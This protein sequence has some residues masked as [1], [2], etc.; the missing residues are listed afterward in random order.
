MSR[1]EGRVALVA[2]GARGIGERVAQ[3]FVRD[4]GRVII[5]DVNAE[6][7]QALAASLGEAAVWFP[8]NVGDPQSCADFVDKGISE[9]GRVDCLVNSA[10]RIR[11]GALMDLSLDDWNET[12]RIGLTGTF[13]ATQ[14]FGRALAGRPGS[15]VNISSIGGRFPYSGSGAYTSVKGAIIR[16]TEQ[17]ALEWASLGIR[18]NAVAPAH[19]E[20]P[21]LAYLQDPEVRRTRSEV[22]PLGRVG[23][24]DD[25]SNAILWLLS[26]EAS[27]VTATT[28]DIDGGLG[29]S[30]MNHLAGRK[31]D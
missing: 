12:L 30:I 25:I 16:L 7:G 14:A 6:L 11:S 1:F 22:T 24:P 17:F 9:F 19:V 4:G 21:L 13:L 20:T 29:K 10:I 5:G 27:W 2:G 31:W 18:V 28:I 15:V 3:D 8:L 26:D 23:Q